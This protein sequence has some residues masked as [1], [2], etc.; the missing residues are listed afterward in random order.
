VRIAVF[1]AGGRTGRRVVEQA[2]ERGHDVTAVVRASSEAPA[3]RERLGVVEGDARDQAT[4]ERALHGA[5]AVISVV[6]LTAPDREPEHSEATAAII[7]AAERAGARRVVVTA[8]N[9]VLT[10]R[11]LTGE[12]A[13]MGREHR[14]NRDA[15]RASDLEWTI[16]AAPWVTDDPATGTYEAVLDARAP[17]KRLGAADFATFTLDALHRDDW[18]RHVV[19]VSAP[20]AQG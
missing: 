3:E 4:V 6:S 1:G 19:G 13:A 10:D 11:E 12:Y 18:I 2:L 14:R 17:G 9:D 16:G 5:D 15:L 8:N 7:A 20:P